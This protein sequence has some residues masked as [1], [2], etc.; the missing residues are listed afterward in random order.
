MLRFPKPLVAAVNGPAVAGGAGLVMACDLVVAT[1][2]RDVRLS[3]AAA[4]HRRRHGR[5]T[6]GVSRRR[7]PGPPGCCSRPRRSRPSRRTA[8]ACFMNWSTTTRSGPGRNQLMG[9]IAKLAPEALQMT[10]RLLN[11]TI[12]EQLLVAVGRRR[13]GQRRLAHH[14]G[15]RR[16]SGR[17]RRETRAEVVVKRAAS[18]RESS[19]PRPEKLP[20]I[21]GNRGRHFG[22]Y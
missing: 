18:L 1:H 8:S 12:G 6:V 19:I 15:R 10:K 3:R 5:A 16:R 22:L 21:A 9:E 7:Q 13:R 11:E 4:W 14:R 20:G 2:R 17:L